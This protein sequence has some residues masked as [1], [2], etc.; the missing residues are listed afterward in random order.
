[1]IEK[2]E[3]L[4]EFLERLCARYQVHL[5]TR[6]AEVY[7]TAIMEAVLQPLAS[8]SSHYFYS[9][10]SQSMWTNCRVKDLTPILSSYQQSSGKSMDEL[11]ARTVLVDDD[12]TNFIPQP[13]NGILVPEFNGYKNHEEAA[14][15]DALQAVATLLQDL[16]PNHIDVRHILPERFPRCPKLQANHET[17]CEYIKAKTPK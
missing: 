10:C 14:K 17:Y 13:S 9:S 4:A 1:V 3:G 15:D 11:L 16:E 2:R 7:A 12:D 6:S 8:S 5:F